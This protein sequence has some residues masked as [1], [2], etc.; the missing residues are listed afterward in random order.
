MNVIFCDIERNTLKCFIITVAKETI[1]SNNSPCFVL[2]TYAPAYRILTVQ[3]HF[4]L[5]GESGGFAQSEWLMSSS[6][7]YPCKCAFRVN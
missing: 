4:L 6:L 1:S 5:H 2:H 7:R 3:N